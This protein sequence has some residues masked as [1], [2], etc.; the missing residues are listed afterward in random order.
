MDRPRPALEL[1]SNQP[2]QPGPESNLPVQLT[3][4]IG[5]E[6]EIEAARKLLQAPE[7]RLLTLTGP[8]EVGKTRLAL[9]LAGDLAGGF[10]DGVRFVALASISDPS[11]VAPTIART[12]G[13]KS[14]GN[15]RCPSS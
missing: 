8:G 3:P 6:R 15:D 9:Q 4:L 14:S 10:A 1:I 12:L 11:L 13:I 7:V 2:D 5:R